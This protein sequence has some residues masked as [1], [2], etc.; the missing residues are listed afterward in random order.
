M[1]AA[2][3]QGTDVGQ[4]ARQLV[5]ANRVYTPNPQVKEVYERNY[6][7]FKRF[8]KSNAANFRALNGD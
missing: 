6:Q 4:L 8:Y 3:I 7:V 2:G 1:I 5:G